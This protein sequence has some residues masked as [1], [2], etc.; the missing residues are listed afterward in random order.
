MDGFERLNEL[1]GKVE[2]SLDAAAEELLNVAEK[3]AKTFGEV[4]D[5]LVI[6]LKKAKWD[7]D[8]ISIEVVKRARKMLNK[9][10]NAIHFE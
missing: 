7:D 9:R 4:K 8:L 1:T 6:E 10:I 5:F 3:N 2:K